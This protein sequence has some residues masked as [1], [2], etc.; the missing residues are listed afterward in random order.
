MVFKPLPGQLA[1]VLG[2]II[3][4]KDNVIHLFSMELQAILELILHDLSVQLCIHLALNPACIS[5]A[6]PEHA[7]PHH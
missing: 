2:V 5:Y 4:L 6:L 1:G 3:L 7:S